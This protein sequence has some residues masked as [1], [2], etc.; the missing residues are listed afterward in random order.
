MKFYK[1]TNFKETPIGKIPKDWALKRLGQIAEIRRGASPRP[2]GDPRYFG[3]NIP[4]IKISDLAKYQR[5][6]YLIRTDDTV[7]DEGKKKSVYLED[8]AL[9]ISNSGTIGRP[10]IIKTGIGGCIHDGFITV[11]PIKAVDKYYLFYF[12]DFKKEEFQL[13]A[14]IGTQGN[15]NTN[16]WRSIKLPLPS[17]EEQQ[18]IVEVLSCVDLAIQKVNEAIVRAERL[19]KGLMQ[20]LLTKG[21]GHKEFKETPIGKIPKTWKVVKL[22]EAVVEVKPGFACGK[23]DDK[24]ILQLRM[25]NIETDGWINPNAGVRVPI[26]E[27]VDDY[28]LKPGD[29]LFNNTNSVDLIGKTAIFRGE[30]PRCV[31]SNHLTRIRVNRS[32]LIP[33]WIMYLFI[34]Y[35][36]QGVF[37]ALCHQHVHQA[38]INKSNLLNLKIYIAP[39]EEQMKIVE[40]LSSTEHILRLKKEKKEKLVKMKRRLMNL[41]LTGKVRV[42][43]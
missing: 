12:F 11:E 10:A 8:G 5:G 42:S 19:K 24:G 28:L 20:Q 15:M 34:R 40:V 21:I 35:W 27:N 16:I 37:R 33:E 31:Y 13:K 4:W 6:F 29:I 39:L 25:D 9:I 43:V 2:K 36:R 41:L 14:Q 7:T 30:F 17:Y 26:P 38:G 18:A 32:K 22:K 23:R 1:E 3:G